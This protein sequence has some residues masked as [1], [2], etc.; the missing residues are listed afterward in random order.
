MTM[1]PSFD[2]SE[3]VTGMRPE[4]D[5]AS[6]VR[7]KYYGWFKS[8][9]GCSECFHIWWNDQPRCECGERPPLTRWQRIIEPLK[10]L[11]R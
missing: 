11:Y 9:S 5:I 7:G 3:P 4:Y 1:P 6:G 2:P 10:V 8:P